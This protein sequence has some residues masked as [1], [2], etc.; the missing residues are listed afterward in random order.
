M[1]DHLARNLAHLVEL[2]LLERTQVQLAEKL[3]VTQPTVSKW[4]NPH[5]VTDGRKLPEPEFRGVA[6]LVQLCGLSLTTEDLMGRDLRSDP[7]VQSVYGASQVSGLDADIL[8]VALTSMDR[9]IR[10]RGLRM[11]GHLGTYAHVL[12]F[13][14]EAARKEFPSGPPPADTR[15]GKSALRAFDK[16][17]ADW[18]DGG[19]A[20]GSIVVESQAGARGG[21][22]KRA[23]VARGG[24]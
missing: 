22:A 6:R 2:A 15:S 8:G 4:K 5:R 20:D 19:I 11:E 23:K 3:G 9:V 10:A 18:L 7:A 12:A 16:K 13:A 24:R 1:S 21:E 14:Y 17:V